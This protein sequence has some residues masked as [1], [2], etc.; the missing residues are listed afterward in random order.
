MNV[1]PNNEAVLPV[2]VGGASYLAFLVEFPPGVVIG[3]FAGSVIFLLGSTAKPKWQWLLYFLVA[4]L[5]GLLGSSL[6]ADVL[7]SLLGIVHVTTI[8]RPGF[9]AMLAA[10]CTINIIG[11]LR[12]NPGFFWTRKQKDGV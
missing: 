12:D 3:A 9:G 5:A 11:W 7:K 4:F 1:I 10:A 6:V 8:V 2:V